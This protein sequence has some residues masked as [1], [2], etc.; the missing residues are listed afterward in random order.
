MPDL[1]LKGDDALWPS[2]SPTI[3]RTPRD[4]WF[5]V[6]LSSAL[7]ATIAVVIF[8]LFNR[9]KLEYGTVRE[10]EPVAISPHDTTEKLV[11]AEDS[12]VA[13]AGSKD[14]LSYLTSPTADTS[15]ALL[16]DS[17]VS[18]DSIVSPD[19]VAPSNTGAYTIQVSAWQSAWKAR[20]EAERWKQL[21]FDAF[22]VQSPPD[23]DGRVWHRVRV[24]RFRTA[25]EAKKVAEGML[26]LLEGG[27]R[28]ERDK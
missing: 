13:N 4:V 9:D 12:V 3:S 5:A 17:V 21:G 20:R 16:P 26:D 2:P 19:P 7:I 28:I 6:S 1:N 23:N 27:Y 11:V 22:V 8:V 10:S 24:G 25:G 15:V 18:S 14:T